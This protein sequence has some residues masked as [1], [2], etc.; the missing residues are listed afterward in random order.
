MNY[1]CFLLSICMLAGTLLHADSATE[2]NSVTA[3]ATATIIK[4]QEYR[5]RAE[6]VGLMAVNASKNAM[7]TSQEA[8]ETVLKALTKGDDKDIERT[9]KNSETALIDFNE[10]LNKAQ[11]IVQYVQVMQ[12][13]IEGIITELKKVTGVIKEDKAEEILDDA[14][15]GGKKVLKTLVKAE[16]IAN[17]LAKKWL[18]SDLELRA[19]DEKPHPV[20]P[21]LENQ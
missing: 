5:D 7:H 2:T 21:D 17:E 18:V 1:T 14:K 4:M 3:Q 12:I 16:D 13:Q 6:N 10:T 15:S 19:A 11:K 8:N 9:R 20:K